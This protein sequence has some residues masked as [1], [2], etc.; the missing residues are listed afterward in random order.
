MGLIFTGDFANFDANQ[1]ADYYKSLQGLGYSDGEIR[2]AAEGVAGAQTDANWNAL[3]GLADSRP[4]GAAFATGVQNFGAPQ[5][6]QFYRDLRTS[7]LTDGLIRQAAEESFGAQTDENWKALQ[8]MSGYV[9]PKKAAASP[10]ASPAPAPAPVFTAPPVATYQAAVAQPARDATFRGYDAA[11]IG[12]LPKAQIERIVVDDNQTVQGRLRGLLAEDSPILQQARARALASMNARGLINSSMATGAADSALYDAATPIAAAD[13]GT[14]ATAARENADAFNTNSRFNVET[15]ANRQRYNADAT[16]QSRA[17]GAQAFNTAELTNTGRLQEVNLA[18]AGFQNS[19]AQFNAGAQNTANLAGFDANVRSSLQN[20]Q[21]QFQ[22]SESAL[23]RAQQTSLQNAAQ[24]FQA[25]QSEIDRAQQIMLADKNITAQQALQQAQ[26]KFQ[27]SE[28]ALDRTQQTALNQA[29]QAFQATQAEK[30]RAQQ[31]M[32]AD[33]N[34]S[35]QQALEQARFTFQAEQSGLDRTQ[36]ASLAEAGRVFQASQAEKDRA[37][38]VMLADKNI[39][40][41]QALEQGRF[42]FQAEQAGLDRTQA[43]NLAEAGRTFQASQ[44]ERDRAQQIM[45]ADKNISAQVALE[46]SR[47]TFSSVEAGLQRDFEAKMTEL[48]FSQ[49]TTLGSQQFATNV[50]ASLNNQISAIL[51]DGNLTPESKDAAI[52]NLVKSANSTL[53]WGSAFYKTPLPSVTAPGATPGQTGTTATTGTTGTSGGGLIN[54]TVAGPGGQA[55]QLPDYF[56][57]YGDVA[58]AYESENA[59]ARGITP[60]QYAQMHYDKFGR[61]EGRAAP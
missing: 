54:T 5:K 20:S 36:A 55:T 45:L 16:N 58:R 29:T 52:S 1:K 46:Q 15:E 18:N 22:R 13:A 51:A 56:S 40:A 8:D 57:R 49:S 34:I 38:Q 37:Q 23:D 3:K 32:L 19:A 33:K 50:S 35:A 25:S 9:A 47:Q 7:G 11:T 39:S 27:S 42:I 44:A 21:Q 17:F 43:V 48:R 24:T 14:F 12:D 6:A 4:A 10:A 30:D 31:I 60:E 59:A 28:S 2:Q 41:Q 26:Q 61:T 53:A